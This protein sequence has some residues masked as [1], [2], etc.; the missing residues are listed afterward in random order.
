[1][2]IPLFNGSVVKPLFRE[3]VLQAQCTHVKVQMQTYFSQYLY[4]LIK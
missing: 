2:A 4:L 3:S 1:M